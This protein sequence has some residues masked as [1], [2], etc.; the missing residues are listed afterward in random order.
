[1]RFLL[2]T[3]VL[4]EAAKPRAAPHL[5]EWLRGQSPLD[6]AVSVLT[7]GEIERGVS[8]LPKGPR[9]R[10]L[11][12]WLSV[13]LPRQFLDRVLPIDLEVARVWGRLAAEGKRAGR[14]LPVI[15]G[16][17][18]ATAAV[19]RLTLVTRNEADCRDRGVPVHNPWSE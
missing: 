6:L 3:N 8:L 16:L 17:L 4:S 15:D 10:A 14:E 9:R 13:D 11:E 18:L 19:H 7:L 2:D 1:M 5:V 12:R